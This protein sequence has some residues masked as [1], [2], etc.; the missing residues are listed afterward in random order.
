MGRFVSDLAKNWIYGLYL[1]LSVFALLV[2]I[3]AYAQTFSL[4]GEVTDKNR[5]AI[6]YASIALLKPDSTTLV[7]GTI[8]DDNGQFTLADVKPGN[9][10]ISV[11]FMGYKSHKELIKVASSQTL[12]F[13]LERHTIQRA[14][15]KHV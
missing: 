8:S 11:S 5:Q 3:I 6:S 15:S 10:V 4:K 1:C 7:G 2:S 14:D 13:T 9:Y 12:S